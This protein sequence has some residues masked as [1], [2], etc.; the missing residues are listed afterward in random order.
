MNEQCT[1]LFKGEGPLWIASFIG[2]PNEVE[3]LLS[4]GAHVNQ[5]DK[6][7]NTYL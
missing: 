3:T 4:G 2:H 1:F 5:T 7:G 6:V